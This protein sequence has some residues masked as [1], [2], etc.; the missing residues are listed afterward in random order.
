M[1]VILHQR[2]VQRRLGKRNLL[3]QLSWL[4]PQ[5]AWLMLS[6]L[7]SAGDGADAGAGV[8]VVLGD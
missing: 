8:G 3:R 5:L 7:G 2:L 4:G 6:E 1:T